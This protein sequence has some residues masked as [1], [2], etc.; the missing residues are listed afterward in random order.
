MTAMFTGAEA[1]ASYI[2]YMVDWVK[3]SK[4]IVFLVP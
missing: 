4:I 2:G 3:G 1:V